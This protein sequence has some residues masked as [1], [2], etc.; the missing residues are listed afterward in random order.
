MLR[1]LVMF[2][3]FFLFNISFS[4]SSQ[5]LISL[6]GLSGKLE[7]NVLA[8][9]SLLTEEEVRNDIFHERVREEVRQGL[10]VFGYYKPI[11]HFNMNGKSIPCQILRVKV[12]PGNPIRIAGNNIVLQGG[13]LSDKDYLILLQKGHPIIGEILDHRKYHNF[14]ADLTILASRKGYFDASMRKSQLLVSEDLYKAFWSIKF[15]SGSRYRFGKVRILGSTM[16]EGYLEN[17]LPFHQGDYYSEEMLS[18]LKHRLSSTNY[19]TSVVVS[20]NFK[21]SKRERVVPIDVHVTPHA[22]NTIETGIGY[23]TDFGYSLKG[24]LK[25]PLLNDLG[26]NVETNASISILERQVLLS[27]KIPLIKNITEEYYLFQGGFKNIAM[28]DSQSFTSKVMASRNRDVTNGWKKEVNLT[29]RLDRFTKGI[30]TNASMLL[31]P[32]IGLN[33]V[34][35]KESLISNL[36]NQQQYSLDISSSVFGSS[37]NF[38]LLQAE[39]VFMRTF[40]DK[41]RLM[42]RGH[43]GWI[44]SNELHKVPMDLRCFA[45]GDYSIRGY[46]HKSIL[47]LEKE[48]QLNSESKI[49]TGSIEYQYSFFDNWWAT[50]FIDAGKTIQDNHQGNIKTGAGIGVHW[51]SPVGPIKIE[52]SRPIKDKNTHGMQFYIGLGPE[53]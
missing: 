2:L 48:G 3:F 45:S 9:L 19:F 38:I 10:R 7:K 17:L 5:A 32:H 6:E 25:K 44:E 22:P 47:Q 30:N 13:A 36:G 49:F 31:Y 39:N 43:M 53:L 42:L 8:R 52:V 50:C 26:H 4:Y 16:K 20:P 35:N 14:K 46:K 24:S 27:Y 23:S 37:V 21:N 40:L 1:Y 33:R 11:I 15:N 18:E 41:H 34:R 12:D 28:N 29:W 51:Q